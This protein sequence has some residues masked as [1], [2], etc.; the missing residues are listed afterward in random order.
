MESH[1]LPWS[2]CFMCTHHGSPLRLCNGKPWE[3]GTVS[4]F[5]WVFCKVHGMRKL[6]ERCCW[7]NTSIVH[8][9]ATHQR[10][11]DPF[12]SSAKGKLFPSPY[13][14][15]PTCFLLPFIIHCLSFCI[16]FK[17]TH[18]LSE[19]YCHVYTIHALEPQS[20][21][22]EWLFDRLNKGKKKQNEWII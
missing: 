8:S 14:S 2:N 15:S 1:C 9:T 11:F 13:Y 6:L 22:I 19:I 21:V 7:M 12:Q 3:I 20:V 17:S 16:L 18:N 4:C 10:V 5:E